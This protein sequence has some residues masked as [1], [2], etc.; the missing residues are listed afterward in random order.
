MQRSF[1]LAALASLSRAPGVRLISL[2][3][4]DGVE[5]LAADPAGLRIETLSAPFDDGDDAFVDTA[6]IMQGL[7][8]IISCDTATAHLAGAL[9]RPV[10]VAL[11]YDADWR[12]LE[13]RGDCPWYPSM[14]LFRQ[15][16]SGD[17]ASVFSAME[18]AL[19]R[20]D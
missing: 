6:A 1:P 7:D 13:G 19:G 12:W 9:G 5:Q 14:R 15:A 10:W 16:A 8:L 18:A 11:P 20:T 2:Q 4:F 3:K 17:W